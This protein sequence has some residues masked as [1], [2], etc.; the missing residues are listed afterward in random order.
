MN[1]WIENK[2]FSEIKIGDVAELRHSLLQKDIELFAIMSGD[3]NPAHVD[4]EFAKDDLFHKI[5]AHGMW[6]ASLISTVLGTILPGPGTIYLDQSLKFSHPIALGDTVTVRLTVTHKHDDKSIIDLDCQCITQDG[7]VAISGTATV[8]A[9]TQKI[10]RKRI[11]MP[12]VVLQRIDS[13]WNQHLLE[14]R[15]GLAPLVTAI[16]HPVDEL[17][18]RGAITAAEEGSIQPI[19]VGPEQKIH[20]AAAAAKLDISAYEIM[21][22]RHSQEAAELAVQLARSGKVEALMKG[23]LHTDELMSAVV[24]KE[25]GLRTGRRMSHVFALEVPNYSKPLF[26]TDAA[27]N[28]FPHLLEKVDIVQNAIDLFVGLGLGVPKVAI[29]SAVEMINEKI[30]ST[31][32][33]AALC[34]MAERGQIH[35][36]ILDGPLAFDN[37]IS[38]ESASVK[39]IISKVAGDADILVVP[40]VE[41][42]NILYKQM[43]YLSTLEAAGMVMGAS[44]PIILTS[45][46]S[47]VFSRTLSAAMAQVYVRRQQVK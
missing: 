10:K 39:G 41:S 38:I 7:K 6:G 17:S 5:I 26:L 34:K 45:R 40:D 31:L 24:D 33:A 8:I 12:S 19:L 14:M 28:L 37:A 9:P 23:A 29:L 13:H 18:L 30:P 21:T 32:D 1:E 36:G 42:G 2:I 47:D 3:V 35:G 15:K 16:V 27:L 43:T 4:A 22:T 44:V 25:T 46:G 20:A 11:V